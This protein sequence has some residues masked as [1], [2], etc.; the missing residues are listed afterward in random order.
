MP[1]F[2]SQTLVHTLGI[3]KRSNAFFLVSNPSLHPWYLGNTMPYFLSQTLIHTLGIDR[4]SN[5]FFMVP[6]L[7]LHPRY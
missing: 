4:R 3:N 7:S 5:V 6:N 2:L 1:P